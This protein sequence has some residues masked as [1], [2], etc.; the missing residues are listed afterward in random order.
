MSLLKHA[1]WDDLNKTSLPLIIAWGHRPTR[2]CWKWF[3]E[4]QLEKLCVALSLDS[5]NSMPKSSEVWFQGM[6]VVSSFKT[7]AA[8]VSEPLRSWACLRNRRVATSSECGG[9]AKLFRSPRCMEGRLH[10]WSTLE[11]SHL[12][13]HMLT[14]KTQTIFASNWLY[15]ANKT[16]TLQT[17]HSEPQLYTVALMPLKS[18]AVAEL[19][20]FVLQNLET[21]KEVLRET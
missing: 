12:T 1:N 4:N 14:L 7:Y 6:Q 17:S 5:M 8:G 9:W 21:A 15:K 13:D 20:D 3:F 16:V 2:K 18:I 19:W 11:G 10:K